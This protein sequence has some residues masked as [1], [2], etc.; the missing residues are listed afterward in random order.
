MHL[1]K[2]IVKLTKRESFVI[3]LSGFITPQ[4][5]W[6]ISFS[7]IR[8]RRIIMQNVQKTKSTKRKKIMIGSLGKKRIRGIRPRITVLI[9][10]CDWSFPIPPFGGSI[11]RS[12][13]FPHP[14]TLSC[15]I[16]I[17][18]LF[19]VW[20]CYSH[21]ESNHTVIIIIIL[22]LNSARFT[23]KW[24]TSRVLLLSP[25]FRLV[26]RRRVYQHQDLVVRSFYNL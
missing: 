26:L 17:T 11:I 16:L 25:L 7:R 6:P 9:W 13:S 20:N 15:N 10:T 14:E 3:S 12:F 21:T 2:R 5:F 4:A 19:L 8:K 23:Q 1:N 24:S 22:L 18:P